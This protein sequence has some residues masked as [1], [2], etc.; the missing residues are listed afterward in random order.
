MPEHKGLIKSLVS[1]HRLGFLT[2]EWSTGGVE[3]S[4]DSVLPLKLWCPSEASRVGTGTDD[5]PRAQ[6]LP[7]ECSGTRQV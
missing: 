7:D 6:W 4:K 1:V 3:A 5:S 2:E